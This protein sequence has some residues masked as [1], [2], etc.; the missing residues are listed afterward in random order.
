MIGT[1]EQYL[2]EM[3]DDELAEAWV[4]AIGTI[5]AFR[6]S[7][8]EKQAQTPGNAQQLLQPDNTPSAVAG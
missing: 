6:R 4:E 2:A 8:K 3:D 1:L 7:Q 5:C